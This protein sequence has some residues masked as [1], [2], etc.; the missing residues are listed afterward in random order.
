MAQ[1]GQEKWTKT[2]FLLFYHFYG[3]NNSLLVVKWNT[4]L[5]KLCLHA[6][7]VWDKQNLS[8]QKAQ[9]KIDCSMK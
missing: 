8:N 3:N 5:Q 7:E 1:E 4:K 9:T 2:F 6:L